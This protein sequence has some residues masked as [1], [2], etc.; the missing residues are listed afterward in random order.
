M[1]RKTGKPMGA[2]TQ[3]DAQ[4]YAKA[5]EVLMPPPG[6]LTVEQRELWGKV[7]RSAP[8]LNKDVYAELLELYVVTYV[9]WREETGLLQREGSIIEDR[10]GAARENPRAQIVK[11]HSTTLIALATKLSI[12]YA[13]H[14]TVPKTEK[15]P[16][17]EP[18]LD[19]HGKPKRGR[20]PKL[21]L[22]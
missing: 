5:S 9:S 1:T 13:Y 20:P 8:H 17:A 4:T 12:A 22:A 2:P 18:V 11:K 16:S 19:E 7:L 10:F 15:T 3:S 6:H 21:R 14:Q